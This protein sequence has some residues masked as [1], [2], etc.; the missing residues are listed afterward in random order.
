MRRRETHRRLT[1]AV[2]GA[3][4]FLGLASQA[5]ARSIVVG[6]T[7]P[8]AGRYPVGA[9]LPRGARLAPG[10][11]VMLLDRAGTYQLRGPAVFSGSRPG[12]ATSRR[13]HAV[14]E[15]LRRR[16]RRQVLS[17]SRAAPER[18]RAAPASHSPPSLWM[19]DIGRSQT[20]CIPEGM[21]PS[22]WRRDPARPATTRIG[23]GATAGLVEWRAGESTQPWPAAVRLRPFGGYA[24]ATGGASFQV[25]LA[26]LRPAPE[27]LDAMILDL[28]DKGCEAQLE[29]LLEE[30]GE[31][32][33]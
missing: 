6:S 4:L 32:L 30:P 7:G 2:L 24:I 18:V 31:A 12:G 14:D 27:D 1:H 17:V 33:R 29:R 16:G 19:L 8:S 3:A 20:F 10:D 15:L 26:M 9:V 25:T 11:S 5:P 21:A 13:A 23:L 28:A 22:L